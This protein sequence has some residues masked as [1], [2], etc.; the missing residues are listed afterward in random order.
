MVI[1]GPSQTVNQLVEWRILQ[2]SKFEADT[3]TVR[4]CGLH[5]NSLESLHHIAVLMLH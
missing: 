5:Q 4:Y 1:R 2:C 3:L